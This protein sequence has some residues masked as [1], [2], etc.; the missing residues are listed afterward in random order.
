MKLNIDQYLRYYDQF[1]LTG[2]EAL[3][4]ISIFDNRRKLI[5]ITVESINHPDTYMENSYCD[6]YE[7]LEE[8]PL[9][10]D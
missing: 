4:F 8:E 9:N 3:K 10:N 6:I 7:R 1:G 5:Q 2:R